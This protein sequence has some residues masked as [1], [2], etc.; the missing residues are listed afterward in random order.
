MAYETDEERLENRP[1]EIPLADFQVLL[2]YWGDEKI[3]V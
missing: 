1:D 2:M 3:Q